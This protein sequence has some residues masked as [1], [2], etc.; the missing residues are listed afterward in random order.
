MVAGGWNYVETYMLISLFVVA[1]IFVIFLHREAGARA[2]VTGNERV[3]R[4]KHILAFG[5]TEAGEFTDLTQ[6]TISDFFKSLSTPE[7]K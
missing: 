2:A 6:H 5:G 1:A 3:A 4:H 7:R